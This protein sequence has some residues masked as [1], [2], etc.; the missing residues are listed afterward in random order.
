MVLRGP[1]LAYTMT[2]FMQSGIFQSPLPSLSA[3]LRPSHLADIDS[4]LKSEISHFEG[5]WVGGQLGRLTPLRS[6]SSVIIK[7]GLQ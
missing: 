3:F 7:G 2:W 5:R 6:S 1:T 4:G